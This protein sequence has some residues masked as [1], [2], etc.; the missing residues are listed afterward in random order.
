[1]KEILVYLKSVG[2]SIPTEKEGNP[3]GKITAN[4]YRVK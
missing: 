2:K 1:M 3:N 4:D